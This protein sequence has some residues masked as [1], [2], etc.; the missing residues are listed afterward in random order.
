MFMTR[1]KLPAA[2]LLAAGMVGL[3]VGLETH[4]LLR[5]S[6]ARGGQGTGAPGK[7]GETPKTAQQLKALLAEEIQKLIQQLRVRSFKTRRAAMRQLIALGRPALPP[8]RKALKDPDL[9]VRQRARQVINAIRTSLD[10]LLENL[11]HED[12]LVRKAAAERLEGLGRAARL[13]VPALVKGS[14]MRTGL[15][16]TRPSAPCSASIRGT[17]SWSTGAWPKPASAASTPSC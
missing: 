11:D 15:S 14:R 17:R 13:A 7:R 2:L 16:G 12:A 10:Y 4:P 3:G 8:L 6:E 1:M 9:E 5:A